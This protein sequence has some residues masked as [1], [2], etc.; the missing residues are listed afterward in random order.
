M[1][2]ILRH[3]HFNFEP[4]IQIPMKVSSE[5][6]RS[7]FNKGLEELVKQIDK[8]NGQLICIA[9]RPSMGK[10]ALMI[11]IALNLAEN[12]IPTAIF[13]LEMSNIQI[14]RRLISAY[15]GIEC[16]KIRANNLSKE[17]EKLLTNLNETLFQFPL[18]IDDTAGITIEEIKNKIRK[19]NAEHNIKV[20]FID[21]LQLINCA[22]EL[23]SSRKDEINH[24]LNELHQIC[25]ELDLTIVILCQR[26]KID[27]DT[28]RD[29][30]D[31]N[32]YKGSMNRDSMRKFD[33]DPDYFDTIAFVHRPM[34]YTRGYHSGE[35][36]G[37]EEPISIIIDKIQTDKREEFELIYN[38][39]I[40][41][42]Y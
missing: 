11:S 22:S 14:I 39:N 3:L 5:T 18:Y 31:S 38:R 8:N 26:S 30:Q 4:L 29:I 35:W 23:L 41:K 37:K 27:D 33:V 28:S 40:A 6:S 24:I 34:Y 13:S 32:C 1:S 7:S 2:L 16:E 36:S 19:L 25:V 15:S 20:I 21:Y 12:N 10:S 17:D 9:G 42:I